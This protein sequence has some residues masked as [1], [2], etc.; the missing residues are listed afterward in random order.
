MVTAYLMVRLQ[1]L[2]GTVALCSYQCYAGGGGGGGGGP[3][4]EVGTLI[5]HGCPT[6]RLLANFEHK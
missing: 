1:S 3:W 4:D 2:S 6:W 5:I